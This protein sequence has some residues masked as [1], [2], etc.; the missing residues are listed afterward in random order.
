M[1][2]VLVSPFQ[3]TFVLYASEIALT[4]TSVLSFTTQAGESSV[5]ALSFTYIVLLSIVSLMVV[6]PFVDVTVFVS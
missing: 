5:T 1:V 4:G 2:T 3:S 6:S